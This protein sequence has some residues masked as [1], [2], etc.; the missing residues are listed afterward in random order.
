[1]IGLFVIWLVL[2]QVLV[3]GSPMTGER[4][5]C[6]TAL[7]KSNFV[8]NGKEAQWSL[9]GILSTLSMLLQGKE[10]QMSSVNRGS[11]LGGLEQRWW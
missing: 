7:E 8:K 10:N 11:A 6:C 1:M 4:R 5:I 2:Y 9:M 3:L